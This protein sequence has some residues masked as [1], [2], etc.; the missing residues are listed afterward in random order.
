MKQ[1][2]H[3][4]CIVLAGPKRLTDE[5]TND[6]LR[7]MFDE[8]HVFDIPDDYGIFPDTTGYDREDFATIESD[9]E[10]PALYAYM[11]KCMDCAI[12]FTTRRGDI[13]DKLGYR[14]IEQSIHWPKEGSPVFAVTGHVTASTP[15]VSIVP[16]VSVN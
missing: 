10:D 1:E 2:I 16:A 4:S 13:A 3:W 14:G 15:S 7:E 11:T 6:E 5:I 12:D 9:M 8:V